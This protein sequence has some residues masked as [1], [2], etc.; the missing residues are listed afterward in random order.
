MIALDL[1][2]KDPHLYY[3][4]NFGRLPDSL[5][6]H[7]EIHQVDRGLKKDVCHW[8]MNVILFKLESSFDS[9]FITAFVELFITPVVQYLEELKTKAEI[10]EVFL[11]FVNVGTIYYC[12]LPSDLTLKHNNYEELIEKCNLFP[13]CVITSVVLVCD[14]FVNVDMKS[15]IK[16]TEFF[17]FNFLKSN[18]DFTV[19]LDLE[20]SF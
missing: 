10:H 8:R 14:F 16:K 5:Q 18:T 1:V 3:A 12:C 9:W 6:S 17:C 13:L 4:Y 15:G 20:L 19:F 7:Y 11:V 2:F